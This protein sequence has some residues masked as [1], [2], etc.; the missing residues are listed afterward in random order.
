[1]VFLHGTCDNPQSTGSRRIMQ[2]LKKLTL[3]QPL[4][5]F[6]LRTDASI[7]KAL[8]QQSGVKETPQFYMDG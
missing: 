4:G 6:D 5:F 2:V 1:M 8:M 3:P 7:E